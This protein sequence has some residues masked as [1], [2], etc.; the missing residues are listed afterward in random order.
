MKETNMDR[1]ISIYERLTYEHVKSVNKHEFRS[2]EEYRK[3]F[4]L[5]STVIIYC[6][7]KEG[8]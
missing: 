1:L 8:F 4:E 2:A 7:Q 3:C 5:L 6:S